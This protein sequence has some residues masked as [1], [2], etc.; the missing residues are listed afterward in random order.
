MLDK[1]DDFFEV[2]LEERRPDDL[3][4]TGSFENSGGAVLKAKVHIE[5]PEEEAAAERE[6]RLKRHKKA[7]LRKSRQRDY[8]LK[9][10]NVSVIIGILT[11]ISM[12]LIFGKR[13]TISYEEKRELATIPEFTLASYF[14]GSFTSGFS[15]FF[16]DAV[17]ERTSFKT[18]ISLFRS[19]F[20]IGYE[21]VEIYGKIPVVDNN[22]PPETPVSKPQSTAPLSS[23]A[24]NTQSSQ[25]SGTSQGSGSTQST[26]NPQNTSS[27]TQTEEPPAAAEND[28]EMEGTVFVIK[29]KDGRGIALF[30]GSYS[31]GVEYAQNINAI[32]AQVGDGV[33]F[34]SL[35]APTSGS[36]YLPKKFKNLMGDE[37]AHIKNINDNLVGVTPVNVFS[38]LQ[39]HADEDIYFKTDHHWQQL[40][41]Y[42]SAEEFARV[43]GVPFTPLSEYTKVERE[44]YVGSLYSYSGGSAEILNNPD[45]FTFYKPPTNCKVTRYDPDLTNK[46][47]DSLIWGIDGM[48]KSSWY[49]I[50][51]VDNVITHIETDCK[52]GRTLVMIGDSYDNAMVSTLVGSFEHIWVGDMR[53]HLDDPY[54]KMNIVDFIQ[55]TGATDVL[56]SAD[57]FSAVGTNRRGLKAM[58]EGGLMMPDEF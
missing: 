12:F 33:N 19:H 51:G 57:T 17:P 7:I 30:G 26:S 55:K 3:R 42:Y 9:C 11:F 46:R 47:S 31:G 40:G 2:D 24:G 35:V 34:Y 45:K 23:S 36:Y 58:L 50:F 13:P 6:K 43:A 27:V 16:N 41:A 48:D 37:D 4:G 22:K 25:G 5:H 39:S 52:N 54:F 53:A 15:E 32:K 18:F 38:I 44:G 20:G 21:G 49:L 10:F 8:S 28:G 29:G 14:D 1:N 56:F